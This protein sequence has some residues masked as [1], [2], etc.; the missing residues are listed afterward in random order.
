MKRKS[1]FTLIELILVVTVIMALALIAIPNYSKSKQR[2]IEKE[3]IA[4][5]KLMAAAERIYKMEQGSYAIC[6][7]ATACNTALKLILNATNWAYSVDGSGNITATAQAST[8][9]SGCSYTLSPTYD[10]E[11]TASGCP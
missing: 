7:G 8:G 6:S 3:A 11:P 5:V 1:G 4:N 10:N 9:M 2:A